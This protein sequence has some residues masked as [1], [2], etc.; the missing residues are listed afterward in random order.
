MLVKDERFFERHGGKAVFLARWLPWLRV[1][2]ALLAGAGGMR[3]QRFLVWNA[4]GG[5]A[6]ATTIALVGYFLGKVASS[7]VGAAGLAL[8]AVFAVVAVVRLL[9]RRTTA[10][11]SSG[12]APRRMPPAGSAWSRIRR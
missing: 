1:G 8:L 5:T 11:S 10:G 2:A 12:S 4:A 7:V 6:W 9:A 3:W